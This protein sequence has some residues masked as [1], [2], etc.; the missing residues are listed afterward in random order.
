[1]IVWAFIAWVITRWT[2]Q[3]RLDAQ[4]YEIK[5]NKTAIAL[6]IL[7]YVLMFYNIII[8]TAI[9]SLA[10]AYLVKFL[11]LD[12][13][14]VEFPQNLVADALSFAVSSRHIQFNL[15]V[16]GLFFAFSCVTIITTSIPTYEVLR[17]KIETL[18]VLLLVL[19]IS[20]FVVFCF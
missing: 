14:N 5:D 9:A 20:A 15:T 8:L 4:L 12:F 3:S 16:I 10:I 13:F 19:Y 6:I 18:F 11:L 7:L 17:S 2:M 1:M